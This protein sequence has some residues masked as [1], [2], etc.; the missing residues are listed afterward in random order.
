MLAGRGPVRAV[1]GAVTAARRSELRR[2]MS[3][4]SAAAA[5]AGGAPHKGHP[6]TRYKYWVPM[7]TQWHHNDMYGHINNS[8][9]N[10]TAADEQQLTA[11][12]AA[13]ASPPVAA[14]VD[15]QCGMVRSGPD[16]RSTTSGS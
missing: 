14:A 16:D 4:G 7:Q 15:T 2:A 3:G 10:A 9:S 8:R 13:P 11:G 6:R 1:L 5:A 12:P